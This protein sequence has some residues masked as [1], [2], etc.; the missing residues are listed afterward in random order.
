MKKK[1][2]GWP[3]HFHSCLERVFSFPWHS[4]YEVSTCHDFEFLG[5]LLA[6]DHGKITLP[7]PPANDFPQ[8]SNSWQVF[9]SEPGCHGKEKTCSRQEWKCNVQPRKLFYW[10]ISFVYWIL[11]RFFNEI[12]YLSS[13][14]ENNSIVIESHHYWVTKWTRTFLG[15]L[16]T[17]QV[18]WKNR[19]FRLP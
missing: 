10:L 1:F 2:P 4:G 18:A 19:N 6:G 14:L 9:T 12:L 11:Q 7:W 3:L 17:F 16:W 13:Q 5:K 8:N 15:Q